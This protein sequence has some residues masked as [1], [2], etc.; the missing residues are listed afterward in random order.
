V[1]VAPAKGGFFYK[2]AFVFDENEEQLE[3]LLADDEHFEVIVF[4]KETLVSTCG[5]YQI[6]H[7][8]L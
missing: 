5:R 1:N 3:V 4:D 6:P 8:E 7:I 2:D